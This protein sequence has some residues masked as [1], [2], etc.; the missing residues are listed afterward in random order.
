MNRKARRA[1]ACRGNL[2]QTISDRSKPR[3]IIGA[4]VHWQNNTP[5]GFSCVMSFEDS[6]AST[7]AWVTKFHEHLLRLDA[8]SWAT[9]ESALAELSRLRRAHSWT[10]GDAI[11]QALGLEACIIISWLESR[12]HL[13]PDEHNGISWV[14]ERGGKVVF[15]RGDR[16]SLS[17]ALGLPVL[18]T[19]EPST[20]HI[21]ADLLGQVSS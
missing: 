10:I 13:R 8:Q 5:D 6:P 3:R 20:R 1:E 21:V 7:R 17:E 14:V 19:G 12:G 15:I 2:L 16:S 11:P 18:I 9:P 4:A